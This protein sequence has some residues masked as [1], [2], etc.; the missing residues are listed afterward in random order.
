MIYYPLDPLLLSIQIFISD[1][2]FHSIKF[3][4]ILTFVLSYRALV[5]TLQYILY[6]S[7][8][9]YLCI[10]SMP[11]KKSRRKYSQKSTK[12]KDQEPAHVQEQKQ[13][14]QDA[15][16]S[17]IKGPSSEGLATRSSMPGMNYHIAYGWGARPIPVDSV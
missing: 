10:F 7:I 3:L 6:L 11:N 1:I 4:N 15:L 12:K 5:V 17:I 9:I 8:Y 14:G 16:T 13:E 2:I